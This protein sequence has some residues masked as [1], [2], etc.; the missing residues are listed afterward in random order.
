MSAFQVDINIWISRQSKKDHLLRC[1]WAPPTPLRDWIEQKGEGRIN[2]LSLLELRHPSS[3]S[4]GTGAP[5][6]PVFGLWPGLIPSVPWYSG[7]LTPIGAHT[8][9]S[10]G[11]YAFGLE[12]NDSSSFPGSSAGRQKILGLF[13][14]ITWWTNSCNKSLLTYLS[15]HLSC[16]LSLDTLIQHLS[17]FPTSLSHDTENTGGAD[18]IIISTF[19]WGDR[20]EK[21]GA[22]LR[23]LR[24]SDFTLRTPLT[25]LGKGLI[26]CS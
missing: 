18:L 7:Q 23:E 4:S 16:P 22:C 1:R 13:T 11:S 2:S 9:S 24:T 26:S 19:K 12:W 17:L 15:I 3:L 5:G 20:S 8:I 21:L 14:S 6:S 10:P 25:S